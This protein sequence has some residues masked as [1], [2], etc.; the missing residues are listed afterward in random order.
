MKTKYLAL[1]KSGARWYLENIDIYERPSRINDSDIVKIMD[2]NSHCMIYLA[3]C[4]LLDVPLK[5]KVLRCLGEDEGYSV[6]YKT[7]FGTARNNICITQLEKY[8][9]T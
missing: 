5:L 6:E 1:N 9:G 2:E 4:R 3:M 7:P 8:T